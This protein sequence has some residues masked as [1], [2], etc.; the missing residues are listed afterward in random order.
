MI[1]V[2]EADIAAAEARVKQARL[3]LA[4]AIKV[5]PVGSFDTFFK[6]TVQQI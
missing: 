6:G 5:N 1:S 2:S 3:K 4:Q